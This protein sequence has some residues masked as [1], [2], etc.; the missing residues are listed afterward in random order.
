MQGFQELLES[1]SKMTNVKLNIAIFTV[2]LIL[3]SLSTQEKF[4]LDPIPKLI[5]Q[6]LIL[7]TSIRLLFSIINLAHTKFENRMEKS[8]NSERIEKEEA[9][10][11]LEALNL[12][13]Q[14]DSNI[15]S[16]DIYQ[17]FVIKKLI[18]Q[19]NISQRKGAVLF[20]LKS[21][22]II[23]AVAIGEHSEGVSLTRIAKKI[24]MEKYNNDITK[25]EKEAIK[26]FYRSLNEVQASS[27]KFFLE[28]DKIKG[29]YIDR[30]RRMVY[31]AHHKV[32][33]PLDNTILF[34]YPHDDHVYEITDIAKEVL[35]ELYGASEAI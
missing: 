10:E 12:E 25:L 26:R 27:L 18:G 7:L 24:L 13:K 31:S 33:K 4:I 3:L 16:L 34:K 5:P 9:A 14:I 21:Q 23:Y 17:L 8:R 32:L 1:L 20:S 6:S 2:Y 30:D 35:L 29:A 22:K 28:V 19:N 11:Q 15:N